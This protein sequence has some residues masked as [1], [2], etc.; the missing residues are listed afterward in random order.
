MA[1]YHDPVQPA[2]RGG[3]SSTVEGRQKVP[4]VK[5]ACATLALA[6][7]SAL[8]YSRRMEQCDQHRRA[9]ATWRTILLLAGSLLL[10][11][12]LGA[13][14]RPR[15]VANRVWL[16]IDG[17]DRPLYSTAPTVRALLD[18]LSVEVQGTGTVEPPLWTPLSAGLHIT[19]T[20]SWDAFE[21]LPI[22][23]VQHTVRDEFLLPSASRVITPGQPGA[24]QLTWRETWDGPNLVGR[25]LTSRVVVTPAVDAWRVQGTRGTLPTT[26]FSGTIA[27]S[28]NGD[29]WLTRRDNTVRRQLTDDGGLDGRVL[30][31]SP[32]GHTL[33]YTRM[34]E[35]GSPHLNELWTLD[36]V[37]LNAQPV[38][39]G[40]RGVLR[41]AWAPSGVAFSFSSAT[42]TGGPP[43]WRA[44]NDLHVVSWPALESTQLLAPSSALLYAWWGEAWAWAPDG[45]R[46]AYARADAVG[47][48]DLTDGRRRTL[49]RFAP[50]PVERGRVWLP[51]L[52]WSPDGNSLL[53]STHLALGEASR[54]DL[55]LLDADTS[56][57]RTLYPDAG[58]DAAFAWSPSGN[59]VALR[60]A[61]PDGSTRIV[62]IA[63]GAAEALAPPR[64]LGTCTAASG[65]LLWLEHDHA[66]LTLCAGDIYLFGPTRGSAAALTASGLVSDIVWR[67]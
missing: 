40:L 26:A 61:L 38:D 14:L 25:E 43:G 44:L 6:C 19:V 37:V 5:I 51:R 36:T 58:R 42:A 8:C 65:P 33:L 57:A 67:P 21:Y 1:F 39:T 28:A 13:C 29:A 4:G 49:H 24:E 55:L 20:R 41:A 32:D 7:S 52:A 64:I 35:D 45:Q 54:Y 2:N 47:L 48:L 3:R 63:L 60:L 10:T 15:A 66:L 18:A 12:A 34:P 50:A 22:A 59:E 56:G 53:A 30:A 16:H 11:A 23:P 27:Y 31:L 62:V 17:T 9:P 46:L